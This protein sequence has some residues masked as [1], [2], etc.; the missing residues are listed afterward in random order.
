MA[1]DA[2]ATHQPHYYVPQ[3]MPW[4][5]FGSFALWLMVIGGVFVMND[6]SGGWISIAACKA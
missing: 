3:P 1:H 4:P 6:A 2:A 5:I